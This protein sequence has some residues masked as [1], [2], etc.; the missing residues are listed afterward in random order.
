[1]TSKV[2]KQI[3]R[4]S[5]IYRHRNSFIEN[6]SC[7]FLQLRK[8]SNKIYFLPCTH[9]P[10]KINTSLIQITRP[11]TPRPP[12]APLWDHAPQFGKLW[13]RLFAG[14]PRA[15]CISALH[16]TGLCNEWVSV[17]SDWIYTGIRAH[18]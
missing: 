8:G 17:I 14:W 13:C 18:A 12:T 3:L 1:V 4:K 5:F 15:R 6:L 7:L 16:W 10:F 2:I 9:I 11:P